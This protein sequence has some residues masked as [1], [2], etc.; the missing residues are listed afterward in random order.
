MGQ[1]H[2]K[3]CTCQE[4]SRPRTGE[5]SCPD[6]F[7]P[8]N[9]LGWLRW[10]QENQC[11]GNSSPARMK[12]TRALAVQET[13]RPSFKNVSLSAEEYI[14]KY[15]RPEIPDAAAVRKFKRPYN[16]PTRW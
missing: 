9:S 8:N 13:A 3:T 10:H 5:F 7:R 15:G 2:C 4:S 16:A 12:V 1:I 11:E 14:A 6:C